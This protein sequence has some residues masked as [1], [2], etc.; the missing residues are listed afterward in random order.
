MKNKKIIIAGGTG[1]IGQALARYFGK[2]NHIVILSRQSING[3]GNLARSKLVKPSEGYNVTYWRWDGIHVEK[4]WAK[5][6]D[7]S[8]I[9]INLAG[10]SVNC[11]YNNNNK[12]EIFESRILSTMALGKAIRMAAEPPKLWINAG[13][14]TI[15]RHAEDH[16]Q[17]E[18]TGTYENDFS[19]QV[20]KQWENAFFEQRTPFTRKVVLRMAITLGLGGGVLEPYLQM[21]HLGL[22]GNHGNGKQMFSWVHIEDICR[23][24]KWVYSHTDMEGVYNC[25]LPNPVTNNDFML[26]LRKITNTQFSIPIPSWMLK[27]GAWFYGTETELLLKSRWVLPTKLL[28]SGFTFKHALLGAALNQLLLDEFEPVYQL[29]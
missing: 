20:C 1:F 26:T 10:K 2:E 18:Y 7:R 25:S 14:A 6:I 19:V 29:H 5:E 22:G 9:I 21:L 3:S 15:Y 28:D 16:P 11:R 13:S 4:H 17:D 27:L 24:I 23:I 8:D 12:R